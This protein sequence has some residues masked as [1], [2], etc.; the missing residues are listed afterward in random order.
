MRSRNLA[1]VAPDV[2][3][4]LIVGEDQDDVGLLGGEV[5][6][7]GRGAARNQSEREESGESSHRFP[8]EDAG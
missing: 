7:C 1:S 3:H 6:V 5:A 2:V 4:A 8:P